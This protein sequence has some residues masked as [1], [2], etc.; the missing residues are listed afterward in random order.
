MKL[1]IIAHVGC[2]TIQTIEIL[3]LIFLFN[4]FQTMKTL[5][6]RCYLN[7][8]PLCQTKH[9]PQYNSTLLLQAKC[10]KTVA[11]TSYFVAPTFQNLNCKNQSINQ[12]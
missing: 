6:H 3:M 10:V 4:T 5:K 12:L 11:K 7:K 1:P 8:P 2:T 9:T